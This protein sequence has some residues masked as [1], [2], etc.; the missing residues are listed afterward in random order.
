MWWSPTRPW[1]ARWELGQWMISTQYARI[2]FQ[3]ERGTWSWWQRL[4]SCPLNQVLPMSCSLALVDTNH[5]PLEKRL[6]GQSSTLKIET[7]RIKGKIHQCYWWSINAVPL[8]VLCIIPGKARRGLR[9]HHD[10]E[11][12]RIRV[13]W[14]I[15]SR[16]PSSTTPDRVRWGQS[17]RSQRR[18][19]AWSR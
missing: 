5:K 1:S 18:L 11:P 8:L 10:R 13:P 2:D 6:V 9:W 12:R 15:P 14:C 17:R 4:S 3:T 19:P 16:I 7:R